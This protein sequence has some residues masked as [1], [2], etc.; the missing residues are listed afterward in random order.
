MLLVD[1]ENELDKEYPFRVYERGCD[2]QAWQQ[3]WKRLQ[4]DRDHIAN[5]G[6]NMSDPS[7]AQT[8]A[9]PQKE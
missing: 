9:V 2:D 6:E 4:V 7:V 8:M 3:A 5:L 1:I